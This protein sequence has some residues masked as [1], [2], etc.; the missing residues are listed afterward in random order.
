MEKPSLG[1][2]I[3]H[4]REKRGWTQSDLAEK[5]GASDITTIYRWEYDKTRPRGENKRRMMEVFGWDESVFTSV[6]PPLIEEA[7]S[8]VHYWNV[9]YPRNP[10]FTG[11][12]G[13]LERLHIVLQS[14]TSAI[15]THA[16]T[17]LG[18]VGKTQLAA[19]YAYRYSEDHKQYKA[20]FWAQAGSEEEL[21][22]SF[23]KFA[24]MLNL[25]E[26]QQQDQQI[27]VE[28]VK[29]WFTSQA[30]WLLVLDN[31]E[32]VQAI[33]NFLPQRKADHGGHIVLT[34]RCQ[35]VGTVAAVPL[36]VES[37]SHEEGATFLLRRVK[38]LEV[39]QPLEQ[40]EVQDRERAVSLS[41]MLGG[42][43]L[44]LD[45]AGAYIEETGCTLAQYIEHY[46]S[47]RAFLLGRR[48]LVARGDMHPEPVTVTFLLSLQKIELA[49]PSAVDLLRFY[50][51]LAPDDIP[52][53][54]LFRCSPAL[55]TTL[56]RL[57]TN[58]VLFD[59][60][61]AIIRRYSLVQR[62]ARS[63][64]LSIHR[65][66]QAVLQDDLDEKHQREHW[67]AMVVEGVSSAFAFAG[68]NNLLEEYEHDIPHALAC[69]SLIDNRNF[70]SASAG[71]LLFLVGYYLTR[72]AHYTQAELIC[73]KALNLYKHLLG[74]VHPEVG[75]NL[76]NLALLYEEMR[77]HSKAQTCFAE[78]LAILEKVQPPDHLALA[79][80][81]SNLSRC[82][83]FQGQYAHA[84]KLSLQSL[85]VLEQFAEAKP[86]ELAAALQNLATIYRDRRKWYHQAGQLY[87]RALGIYERILPP[88]HVS[89]G[90]CLE[91]M[92]TNI[93]LKGESVRA[94]SLYRRA[95]SIFETKWGL[96]HPDVA[97]CLCRLADVCMVQGKYTLVEEYN[98]Q[99]LTVYEKI[100][101]PEYLEVNQPLLGLAML[102]HF[103][104]EKAEAAEFYRRAISI[105]E[106]SQVLDHP[107]LVAAFTGYAELLASQGKIIDAN[108]L[109]ARAQEIEQKIL[110]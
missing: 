14:K 85:P 56:Q 95:L 58:P 103:R 15:L 100:G 34:T 57:V 83:W 17:G 51:F 11:R 73:Q 40:A 52:E 110:Q 9:P 29:K 88:D 62:L 104:G 78:A 54:L 90:Y 107:D 35:A 49:D 60:A 41:Q 36:E 37:M 84:E 105:I 26:K 12:Q 43:P 97:S 46:Q 66:V 19:E 22:R 63:L 25:E 96:D 42:L 87:Q 69:V 92:A 102:Y 3:K 74:P 59:E 13:L 30:D 27:L 70:E 7:P 20:V 91:A 48:G 81:R 50:A 18:G 4:E 39:D 16:V 28:A 68:Q 47:Q 44:A 72:R 65:V 53:D 55:P 75:S 21:F 89:L 93:A 10:Y 79:V 38:I 33:T 86:L 99:A 24:Q 101:G 98:R 5:I 94:E 67:E 32:D 77:L 2:L 23:S 71:H 31:V 45:Q 61:L 1:F 64:S 80:T 106:K 8:G 82:Y 108:R 6:A 76:S 109:F